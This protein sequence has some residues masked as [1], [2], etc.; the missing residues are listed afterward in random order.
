[1]K[2]LLILA[3]LA[4]LLHIVLILFKKGTR[5]P[6][7][8]QALL[9][10]AALAFRGIT[11]G[12]LPGIGMFESLLVFAAFLCFVSYRQ[13]RPALL[14]DALSTLL[15]IGLATMP[16]KMSM[17]PNVMPAL[18]S[19][20]FVLHVPLFFLGYSYLSRDFFATVTG[21]RPSLRESA[22]LFGIGIL[23]GGIWAQIAWGSF[24]SWDPKETWAL[25]TWLFILAGMH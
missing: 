5:Y 21:G 11:V 17:P 15:L 1:M 23:T 13:D 19:P 18:R 6:W 12:R 9:L 10:L 16:P 22:A 24:W 7:I 25:V 4:G 20:L 2:I 14:T 8:A 3:A